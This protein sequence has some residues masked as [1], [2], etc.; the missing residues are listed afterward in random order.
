LRIIDVDNGYHLWTIQ[1]ARLGDI[2]VSQFNQPFI[3]NGNHSPYLVGSCCSITVK[4]SEF[5]VKT[6]KYNWTPNVDIHPA[7]KEQRETL[8]KAMH[9][10][11]YKWDAENKQL[12]KIEQGPANQLTPEEASILDKH[13]DKLLNPTWSEEDENHIIGI[14][15]T[16]S[17][18]VKHNVISYKTGNMQIDWLK[19]LSGRVVQP[20]KHWKPSEEQ[21][22]A[23]DYYANSLCTYC[24]R[25]DALRSLFNVLKKL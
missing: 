9:E 19:S 4:G 12:N 8:F 18:A 14:T 23:L 24:D 1:D 5:K 10:K 13:I 6:G 17:G 7:T 16:I 15:Q 22:E 20:Q 21:M 11:G 2:L 3:Y 25:Q